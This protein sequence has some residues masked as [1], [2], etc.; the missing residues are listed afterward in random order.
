VRSTLL[1]NKPSQKPG[2]IVHVRVHLVDQYLEILENLP[3]TRVALSRN[4]ASRGM[5]AA[6]G[7]MVVQHYPTRIQQSVDK[8]ERGRT[9]S[10]LKPNER[11]QRGSAQHYEVE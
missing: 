1:R 3:Q 10:V 2:I 11:V 4:Q 7:E 9:R 5:T 6:L 8:V